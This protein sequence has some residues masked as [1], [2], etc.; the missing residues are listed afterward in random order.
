VPD[1]RRDM[2][3]FPL[4]HAASPSMGR[5]VADIPVG[6]RSQGERTHIPAGVLILANEAVGQ[7]FAPWTWRPAVVP[8]D[9]V[10]GFRCKPPQRRE[11]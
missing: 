6:S 2:G 4:G 3:A 7:L 10:E 11:N 1:N 8:T 5:S 9:G